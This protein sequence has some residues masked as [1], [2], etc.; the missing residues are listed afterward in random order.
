MSLKLFFL[1]FVFLSFL[2]VQLFKNE[3][4]IKPLSTSQEEMGFA[5]EFC[6][7]DKF[8]NNILDITES[9]KSVLRDSCQQIKSK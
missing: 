2:T 1:C 5:D 4:Y 3:K 7:T 8:W 6:H 9:K